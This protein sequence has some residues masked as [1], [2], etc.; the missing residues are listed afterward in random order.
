MRILDVDFRIPVQLGIVLGDFGVLLDPFRLDVEL[1]LVA[2][3]QRVDLANF[4]DLD[5]QLH[6]LEFGILFGGAERRERGPVMH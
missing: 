4:G 3:V 2:L 6:I 1:G 5:E